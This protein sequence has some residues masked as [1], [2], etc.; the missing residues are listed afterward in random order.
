MAEIPA[1]AKEAAK[2][3]KELKDTYQD[4]TGK[5]SSHLVGQADK[6]QPPSVLPD[7]R[8]DLTPVTVDLLQVNRSLVERNEQLVHQ[9]TAAQLS[10][11]DEQLAHERTKYEFPLDFM[12]FVV[13]TYT[14]LSEGMALKSREQEHALAL[15]RTQDIIGEAAGAWER[16]VGRDGE[17]QTT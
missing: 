16:L 13:N 14:S 15:K 6:L 9:T 11:K 7:V 8:N 12:R 1:L 10:L 5:F 3:A 4:L 2:A 17:A